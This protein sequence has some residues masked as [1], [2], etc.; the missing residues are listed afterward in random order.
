VE[1]QSTT[2]PEK[3]PRKR[4]TSTWSLV[5]FA[6][7]ALYALLL[8]ILNDDKVDVSFVFFTAEISLLV[9]IVLCLGLGFAAGYLADRLRERRKSRS[10]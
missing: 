5:V 2:P 6:A 1:G 4:G 3:G 7:V 9:L 10:S 8:V